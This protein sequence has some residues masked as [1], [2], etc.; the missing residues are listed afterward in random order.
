MTNRRFNIGRQGEQLMNENLFNAYNRIKYIG[1][2]LNVPI[3]Q[4]QSPIPDYS[5]WINRATGNDVLN[6]YNQASRTWNPAFKGYYH[7]INLKEQPL[8]PVDGQLFIDGNGVLRYYEDKQ[9][10]VVGA[11]SADDLSSM[12]MGIDNFLIMPDMSPL[13]GTQR[14]YVVPSAAV[15]KLFDNKKFIPKDEYYD[16]SIRIIYPITDGAVPKE[17]VSWVHVNPAFLYDTRKRLIR[18]TDSIK[19]NNYFISTPTTNTEFYGYKL[20]NPAGTLLRYIQDYSNDENI[21]SES[22]DTISDYRIVNGGIQLL[23][24]AT[25]LYDFIYA[26]TYKFDTIES[27]VGSVLT[28]SSII[29]DNNQVYVGQIAG[30]PL[31][32]LGGLYYEQGEYIYNAREG[33][34]TFEG[35]NIS[36]DM[37]LTVAAFADV[38]RYPAQ[39][40]YEGL[41]RQQR[42][43]FD[44]TVI[45]DNVDSEGNIV[46][47]HE[48][49]KQAKNFKHPIAFVQ[50]IA[51][52]YDT[53][54]GITDEIELDAD[55]GQ[56]KVFNFG[57]IEDGDEVKILV[58]DIGDAKLSSGYTK[59]TTIGDKKVGRIEDNRITDDKKYLVFING[60]CTAPSDHEVYNGYIE[61]DN[62]LEDTQYILMS[63][64]KGNTGIDLLFDSTVAY[65][66]FQIDDHNEA[67][68]YNDCNMVTSYI[69]S[70]DDSGINGLL[71]DRTAIQKKSIGEET[72]S[73]GEIL[74]LRDF[75]DE[76]ASTYVY[77]IF[78][79]NGD[80]QWTT[81]AEKY[82]NDEMLKLD[83]MLV[84]LNGPGSV[85]IISNSQIKNKKITYYAY[86]YADETDE[87][88]LKGT[89]TY[90][91]AV[92]DH[93]ADTTIPETQDFYVRRTHYYSPIG[94]GILGTYVNGIQVRSYDDENVECKY[95]IPTHTNIN[96][97]K[98]WGNKCDL[99][100]LIKTIN[101]TTTV[102]QL[103]E[104]KN[105]EFSEE[106]KD[107]SIT[108]SLLAR[109]KSLHNA[110]I[111]MENNNPLNYFVERIE[112][113]EAFS[114][115]RDWCT[116]A[117]RYTPFTNTYTSNSYIG[118]GNVDIYLNGVMLDRSSYS[119]FD[120]CNVILND[121]DVAGGSDEFDFDDS[122]SHRLIKYYIKHYDPDTD[123]TIGEVK[124][125]YC[126]TPDE[127]LIE[128]RPDTSLRKTS[129]EIKEVTYDT[130]VLPYEDYEFPNSLINSKDEIKIWIDGILYTGGYEIKNK[131][132]VLKN[133]PLQPDPI[134]LYFDTHPDTYREWKKDN[135]EYTYRR[136]RIIFE[137]R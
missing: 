20:G 129:Y 131:D 35:A 50:G 82:G 136:S 69:T 39:G 76:D 71:M 126:E 68:V 78:N 27:S 4:Y 41:E 132:I 64:D 80:Y 114:A 58:A 22:T 123:K 55:L 125:F 25:L 6:V 77:K 13:T 73:T 61:I 15:G 51:T 14:D 81:Y 116:F 74:L 33:T 9:W 111:E 122:K 21:S 17:K 31:V 133:S 119:I 94:K 53:D 48:Y 38:V 117:N 36:N 92:K 101:D 127:V 8:Y 57:P 29:G 44:V 113:G 28:G 96:F 107:Y 115:N 128:Y 47:Q 135:G 32:F 95:H 54:Y 45:K 46:I 89:D 59:T 11:A 62:L 83:Q 93:I 99:Y 85:S 98:T 124:R 84:Q 110:L 90:K 100:N 10:K 60:I 67:S 34:L 16:R 79:V 19:S 130:G 137:W 118:P 91:Y 88:I 63:L 106:L 112:Q 121:L 23:N 109:F 37:D 3:Q 56:I 65:Y 102:D 70:D 7:P 1:N 18:I 97:K 66:T 42:P 108:D 24:S 5:L 12:L 120:S 104:M 26:I 75:A 52:L 86:S 49:L 105:G 43:P 134:R 87:P 40:E 30:F 103:I 2:G 72:Y